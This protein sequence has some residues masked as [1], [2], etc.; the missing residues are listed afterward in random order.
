MASSSAPPATPSAPAAQPSRVW[1][2][3][4]MQMRK[5][6]PGLPSTFSFGTCM[7]SKTNSPVG[8]Q[9]RPSLVSIGARGAALHLLRLD[10]EGGHAL[11]ALGAV[12]VGVEQAGVAD[13]RLRDPHLVAVHFVVVALVDRVRLHAG[14]VRAGVGLGHG[15]EAELRA[16]DPAGD[17]LLLLLRRAELGD[18]QRRPE[19]L[20]VE[21]QPPRR[22]DLARSARPSAPIP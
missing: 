11:V 12:R 4:H 15:E 21:R 22:R 13:L 10:D 19:I 9:C 17:V 7:P 16:G 2:S 14:D 6:S 8:E 18:G 1:L 3:C 20:H 5:P